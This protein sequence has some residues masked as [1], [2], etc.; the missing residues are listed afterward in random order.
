MVSRDTYSHLGPASAVLRLPQIY[1]AKAVGLRYTA[2]SS[3]V[4]S[5]VVLVEDMSWSNMVGGCMPTFTVQLSITTKTF[6]QD[7]SVRVY[8][9]TLVLC[10]F[11]LVS[12]RYQTR[13]PARPV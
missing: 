4:S 5:W 1:A 3:L 10:R 13:L 2:A 6:C 12:A 9:G 11:V 8:M 7:L